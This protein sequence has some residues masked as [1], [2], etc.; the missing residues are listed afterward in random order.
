MHCYMFGW[1]YQIVQ[2]YG[3]DPLVDTGYDLLRDGSSVDVFRV[4]AIA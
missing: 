2:L 4:Q 1:A 3:S